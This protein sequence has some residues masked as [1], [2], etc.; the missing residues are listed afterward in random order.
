MSASVIAKDSMNGWYIAAFLCRSTMGLCPYKV[1]ISESGTKVV[2]S[3]AKKRMPPREKNADVLSCSLKN[4][5]PMITDMNKKELGT[6]NNGDWTE[7][8]GGLTG[9]ARLVQPCSPS[10]SGSAER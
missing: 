3:T 10:V 5:V 2:K 8:E 1:G 6:V 7:K 9:P 4:T